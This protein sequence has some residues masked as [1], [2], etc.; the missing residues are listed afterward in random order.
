MCCSRSAKLVISGP[1]RCPADC[2]V[3]GRSGLDPS[4]ARP[5]AAAGR[6]VAAPTAARDSMPGGGEGLPA[7]PLP[8]CGAGPESAAV[9]RCLEPLPGTPRGWPSLETA[10]ARRRIA[11]NDA[12]RARAKAAAVRGG[13]FH[14]AR[15]VCLLRSRGA[16]RLRCGPAGLTISQGSWAASAGSP[17]AAPGRHGRDVRRRPGAPCAGKEA[18]ASGSKYTGAGTI[19]GR[20]VPPGR[21]ARVAWRAGACGEHRTARAR[22]TVT[23]VGRLVVRSRRVDVQG[24]TVV[25][26]GPRWQCVA[27]VGHNAVILAQCQSWRARAS[28]HD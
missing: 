26:P 8:A 16:W 9:T 21:H 2:S 3:A 5:T 7:H 28:R 24:R 18:Y 1:P 27:A 15:G 22:R 20:P 23:M 25:V 12:G 17:L 10:Q 6:P 14:V 19:P 13:R 4:W 11:L